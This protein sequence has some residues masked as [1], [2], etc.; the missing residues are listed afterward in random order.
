MENP[1]ERRIEKRGE[2]KLRLGSRVFLVDQ[3]YLLRNT[4]R[5][6]GDLQDRG[7]SS[8]LA[9]D[10]KLYV[11]NYIKY[12]RWS[13]MTVRSNVRCRRKKRKRKNVNATRVRD[14]YPL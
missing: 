1:N 6:D 7:R 9:C 3:I 11:K 13:G 12:E 10:K 4:V 5:M 8:V 2:R 14:D